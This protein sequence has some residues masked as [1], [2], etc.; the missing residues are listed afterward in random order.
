MPCKTL[1]D[2]DFRHFNMAHDQGHYFQFFLKV[3][4][5]Y[6]LRYSLITAKSTGLNLG[7]RT[8]LLFII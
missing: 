7:K 8:H 2:K 5:P 4:D 6:G 3:H 1:P